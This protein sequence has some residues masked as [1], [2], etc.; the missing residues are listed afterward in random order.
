MLPSLQEG[1]G[2]RYPPTVVRGLWCPKDASTSQSTARLKAVVVSPAGMF[3]SVLLPIA[4]RQ[5][6]RIRLPSRRCAPYG[7]WPW[8]RDPNNI[9]NEH[10]RD[11]GMRGRRLVEPI[12]TR[13]TFFGSAGL[14]GSDHFKFDEPTQMTD[15]IDAGRGLATQ[16]KK[17]ESGI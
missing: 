7:P 12:R 2:I 3:G 16:E 15:F 9:S 6:C 10:T 5:K 17:E 14:T 13:E 8:G 4:S 1:S 11:E